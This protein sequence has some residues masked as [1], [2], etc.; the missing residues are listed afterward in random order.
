MIAD[1][2][3]LISQCGEDLEELK[4]ILEGWCFNFNMKISAKKTQ[5]IAPTDYDWP[6]TNSET[7]ELISLLQVDDYRYL[8]GQYRTKYQYSELCGRVSLF[9]GFFM[10][11]KVWSL[12]L[13]YSLNWMLFKCGLLRSC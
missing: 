12:I 8:G 4:A 1:D 11:W 10:E 5:I 6:I 3:F 13:Q 7:V 9:R 2:I